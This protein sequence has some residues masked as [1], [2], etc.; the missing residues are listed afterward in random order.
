MDTQPSSSRRQVPAVQAATERALET[1]QRFLHIEAIG[2]GV[3]LAAA[4]AAL[5]WANSPVAESYHHFWHQ[6]VGRIMKSKP[7]TT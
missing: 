7:T 6:P 3:L 2:G 4:V 1:L 5:I